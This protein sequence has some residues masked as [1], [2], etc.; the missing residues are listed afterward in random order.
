LTLLQ[1]TFLWVLVSCHSVLDWYHF[2]RWICC[3][4]QKWVFSK[5]LAPINQTTSL[6]IMIYILNF[7][8]NIGT[9]QPNYVPEDNDLYL[10]FSPKHWHLSTKLRPWRLW[11][12]SWIFSKT[13]A[14]I[15]QT[16]SLN[17]MIYILNFLQNVGTYQPNY[18][19]ED[20]DLYL[21][22]SPKHWYLSTKL[23]PWRLWFMSWIFFKT[24]APINQTTSLKIMIYVFNLLQNIGT[25]QPN[26][27]PEDND[28]CLEFSPKQ[29]HLWTKLRPWR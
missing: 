18:V 25:Y 7:L 14:P 27:I 15:N 22:F 11:F 28:L 12:I 29:W 19:P 13:L 21:E 23:C 9:Y 3:L 2:V 20:N 8:Q 26:Y 16:T 4:F 10:E 5:T 17:I 1:I 24:L 6:K